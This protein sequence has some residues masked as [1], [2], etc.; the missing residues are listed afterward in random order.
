ML[1]TI[2][3][4][5]SWRCSNIGEVLRRAWSCCTIS[6]AASGYV[7]PLNNA[8]ESR[9]WRGGGVIGAAIV[10]GAV[11]GLWPRCVPSAFLPPKR[12]GSVEARAHWR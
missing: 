5:N 9:R 7:C 1:A 2:L 11:V 12:C 6:S 3:I 10:I 8:A 4:A